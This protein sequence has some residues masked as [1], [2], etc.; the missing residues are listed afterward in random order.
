MAN[1]NSISTKCTSTVGASDKKANK[2]NYRVC[3]SGA[4]KNYTETLDALYE[5]PMCDDPRKPQRQ[6]LDSVD[7]E[8]GK[9]CN[10]ELNIIKCQTFLF[11]QRP[12]LPSNGLHDSTDHVLFLIKIIAIKN[13]NP[14]QFFKLDHLFILL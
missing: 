12:T 2:C 13:K 4:E 7:N 11:E 6:R 9:I 14:A 10:T 1:R 5:T 8:R 3:I